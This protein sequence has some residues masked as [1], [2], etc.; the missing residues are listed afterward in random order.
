MFFEI[1]NSTI[2]FFNPPYKCE[3]LLGIKIDSKLMFDDHV[4][5]LCKKASQNLNALSRV[6]YQ[7]DFNQRAL[8]ECIYH[9]SVFLRSDCL[10]VSQS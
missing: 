10:D 4:K 7:L 8:N 3:K 1:S 6:A 2:T 9:I 5:S